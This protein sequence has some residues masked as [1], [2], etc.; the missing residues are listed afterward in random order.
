MVDEDPEYPDANII[1]NDF[2]EVFMIIIKYL[3]VHTN[4]P[5]Y[6]L[7]SEIAKRAIKKKLFHITKAVITGWTSE[8]VNLAN[9]ILYVI[10]KNDIGI[11]P[12]TSRFTGEGSQVEHLPLS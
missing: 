6:R 4:S 2:K 9:C 5:C 10:E 12:A 1:E 8:T 3:Y 11:D 7:H